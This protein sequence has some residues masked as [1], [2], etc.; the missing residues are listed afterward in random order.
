MRKGI[1]TADA[2]MGMALLSIATV[3]LISATSKTNRATSA[4]SDA[5]RAA[6]VAEAVLCDLQAGIAPPT[7]DRE[8]KISIERCDGG[9]PVSGHHWVQVVVTARGQQ[10][11]LVGLVPDS[12]AAG[13]TK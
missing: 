9:A 3:I 13:G 1:I 6:R 11:L 8:T 10:R 2:L 4:L 7:E 5:R 12:S